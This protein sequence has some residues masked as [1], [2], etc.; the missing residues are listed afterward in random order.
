MTTEELRA[1]FDAEGIEYSTGLTI[2]GGGRVNED[3][4]TVA[5]PVPGDPSTSLSFEEEDGHIVCM[6]PLTIRQCIAIARG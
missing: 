3:T 6:D 2:R 5:Y 1:A 4:V